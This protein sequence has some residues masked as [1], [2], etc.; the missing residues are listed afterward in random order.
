MF[1]DS[2]KLTLLVDNW[3]AQY[4]FISPQKFRE[5]LSEAEIKTEK[6]MCPRCQS[7]Y[8]KSSTQCPAC[9]WKEEQ[10]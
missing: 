8:L 3:C 5:F 6:K 1:I 2:N 7:I 9:G 4:K 10:K